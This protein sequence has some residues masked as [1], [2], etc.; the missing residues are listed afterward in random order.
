MKEKRTSTLSTTLS[1]EAKEALSAFCLKRGLKINAFLEEV[2]WDR[3][4]EEMDL[5][6]A[7]QTSYD[8]L[9]DLEDIKKRA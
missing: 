5:E 8:D 7:N 4:E 3:L 9:T 6:L 2:I 1:I